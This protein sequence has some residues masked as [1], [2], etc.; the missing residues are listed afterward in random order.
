LRDF[1][2]I[3]SGVFNRLENDLLPKYTYHNLA[4]TEYV[5][6]KTIELAVYE[7]LSE[8][9]TLLAKTAAVYHD[10]GWLVSPV[11]HEMQSCLIARSELPNW[12][13][14]G[15]EVE[16]I[17]QAIMATSIPQNPMSLIGRVLADADLYYLGTDQ[18]GFYAEKLF[19]EIKNMKPD[20]SGN[21]WLELQIGFL[22]NHV[23]H[24]AFAQKNLA[25]KK[26]N[27]LHSLIQQR[28]A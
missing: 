9:D 11:K 21:D 26:A 13:F 17:C 5:L 23:Y 20:F 15:N 18:Y 25:P 2:K 1:E 24:T 27:I 7:G 3:K 28:A 14:N 19:E 16:Q 8:E 6:S 22:E 12:G 4:H 10:I